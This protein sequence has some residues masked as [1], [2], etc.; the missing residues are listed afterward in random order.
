MQNQRGCR[1]M[2]SETAEEAGEL[3]LGDSHVGGVARV[4]IPADRQPDVIQRGQRVTACGLEAAQGDRQLGLIET[5]T[6]VP[7]DYQTPPQDVQSAAWIGVAERE[8][9]DETCK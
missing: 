1:L 2:A 8:P 7:S 5:V 6:A 9:M 3:S 4:V